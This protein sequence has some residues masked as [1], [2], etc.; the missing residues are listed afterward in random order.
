MFCQLPDF[1]RNNDKRGQEYQ[2]LASCH[3]TSSSRLQSSAN[4][5]SSKIRLINNLLIDFN[6]FLGKI[7]KRNACHQMILRM[8][9]VQIDWRM[10]ATSFSRQHFSLRIVCVDNSLVGFFKFLFSFCKVA[11]LS[12]SNCFYCMRLYVL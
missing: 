4:M 3:Q 7:D 1:L 6:N 9:H 5:S 10:F 11:F 8:N 12:S 2:L